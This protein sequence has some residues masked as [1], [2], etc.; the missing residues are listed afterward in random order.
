M[1]AADRERFKAGARK[2]EQE[3]KLTAPITNF[4]HA[5]FIKNYGENRC[6]SLLVPATS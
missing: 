6:P 1:S 2:E 4:Y 3:T 5:S